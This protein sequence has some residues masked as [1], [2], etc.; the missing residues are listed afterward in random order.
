MILP[1]MQGECPRFDQLGRLVP[2]PL[3]GEGAAG[4]GGGRGG[5]QQASAWSSAT[6]LSR[7]AGAGPHHRGGRFSG[8]RTRTS[9]AGAAGACLCAHHHAEEKR[10]AA[11]RAMRAIPGRNQ[12]Q[13]APGRSCGEQSWS[14]PEVLPAWPG[15]GGASTWPG[16]G[17]GLWRVREE[18]VCG[19]LTAAG[20]PTPG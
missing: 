13:P 3:G 19:D 14:M 8:W 1:L 11:I 17:R 7:G 9:C 5:E 12:P 18:S 4:A 10:R 6:V 20:T 16:T 15:A 2:G